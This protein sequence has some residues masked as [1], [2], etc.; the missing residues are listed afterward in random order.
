MFVF[1]KIT[2]TGQNIPNSSL[3]T[4]NKFIITFAV[5]LVNYNIKIFFVKQ[6]YFW[7]K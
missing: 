4:G 2:S 5:Y 6:K 7:H 1:D 3:S